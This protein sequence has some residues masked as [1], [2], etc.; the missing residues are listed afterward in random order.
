M[1]PCDSP[2]SKTGRC[3]PVQHGET[4][5]RCTLA[6]SQHTGFT[7]DAIYKALS[8]NGSTECL[9]KVARNGGRRGKS[10]KVGKWKWP[11]ITALAAELKMDRSHV[12]KMSRHQ[13]ERLLGIVMK[14]KG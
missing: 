10:I 5:Y 4:V 14:V 7:R 6:M 3:L 2:C 9:G 13:K 12:D 11:S 8:R 1:T